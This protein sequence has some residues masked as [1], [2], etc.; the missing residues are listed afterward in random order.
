MVSILSL[1]MQIGNATSKSPYDS[2]YDHGC[3]DADISNPD[4]RYINQPEK[5]SSFH[6]NE[7]MNGYNDGYDRCSNDGGDED[8]RDNDG[9]KLPFCDG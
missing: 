1:Q 9:A 7:F 8:D 3:D 2:G 5:G 4:D 6:T